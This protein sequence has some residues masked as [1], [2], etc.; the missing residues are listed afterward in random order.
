VYPDTGTASFQAICTNVS[1]AKVLEEM[2]RYI[3]E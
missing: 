1:M 3:E 2:L